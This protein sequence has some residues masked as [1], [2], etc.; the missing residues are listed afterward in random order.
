[1]NLVAQNGLR[2]ATSFMINALGRERGVQADG[3]SGVGFRQGCVREGRYR[4]R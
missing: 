3:G 4:G 1:M 2:S